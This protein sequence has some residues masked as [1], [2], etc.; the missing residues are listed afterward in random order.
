MWIR[1]SCCRFPFESRELAAHLQTLAEIQ[2]FSLES[3]DAAARSPDSGRDPR[4]LT[5][6]PGCAVTSPDSFRDPRIFPGIPGSQNDFSRFW[7]RSRD[8]RR[9]P[10]ISKRLLRTLAEVQ[11]FSLKSLDAR[12]LLQILFEIQGVSLESRDLTPSSRDS[13][14][15]LW[16]Q[17][18]IH[19]FGLRLGDAAVTPLDSNR[20]RKM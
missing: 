9:N 12:R 18:A 19:G 7:P 11:G 15:N 16:I 6:I 2:R 4:I 14:E 5:G 17:T 10:W 8:S 3:L 13:G 1:S 20:S